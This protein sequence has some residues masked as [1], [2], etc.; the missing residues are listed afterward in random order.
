MS[1]KN[2]DDTGSRIQEEDLGDV[3]WGR[4]KEAE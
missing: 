1:M 3:E 4:E 2:D